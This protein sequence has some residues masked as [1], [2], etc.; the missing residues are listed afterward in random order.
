MC[1]TH[2]VVW[3]YKYGLA[4]I[5][6]LLFLQCNIWGFDLDSSIKPPCD[7]HWKFYFEKMPSSMLELKGRRCFNCNFNW[8]FTCSW[9]PVL[10]FSMVGILKS[11]LQ[12]SLFTL[13]NV[14][15]LCISSV[16]DVTKGKS[17]YGVGGAYNHFAGRLLLFIC[18]PFRSI[19]LLFFFL[20]WK[21][22]LTFGSLHWLLS[23]VLQMLV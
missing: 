10:F 9:V 7:I 6:H 16:Y 3:N 17:H 13:F 11:I 2:M 21:L 23:H 1:Y 8:F 14:H 20:S 19:H 4:L 15:G 12:L 18:F 5:D 22:A